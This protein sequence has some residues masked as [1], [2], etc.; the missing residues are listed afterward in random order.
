M[1]Y[2]TVVMLNN[3]HANEWANDPELGQKILRAMNYTAPRCDK[4]GDESSELR[5]NCH[6]GRVV[7]CT[8]SSEVSLVELSFYEGFR[9]LSFSQFDVEDREF[10]LLWDAANKLGYELVMKGK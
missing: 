7:Q 10:D 4:Y 8:H 3:D 1:G 6:Y 5:G 2:R 9:E